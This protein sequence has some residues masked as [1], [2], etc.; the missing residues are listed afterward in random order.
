MKPRSRNFYGTWGATKR[1]HN[2]RITVYR[3][4]NGVNHDYG[5]EIQAMTET[6][7][8]ALH[9]YERG[10]N[11]MAFRLSPEAAEALHSCLTVLLQKDGHI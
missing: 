10:R 5:I 1:L 2:R 4:E 11:S 3:I 8:V 6:P 9:S 7:V